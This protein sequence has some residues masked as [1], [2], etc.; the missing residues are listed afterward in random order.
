ME[1]HGFIELYEHIFFPLKNSPIKILEIEI[2]AG[3]SLRVW[4]KYFPE[5]KIYGIDILEKSPFDPE[6]IKTFVAEQ[7][8]RDQLKAFINKYGGDFDI[9]ID[10]GGHPMNQQ[11]ISL[12]FLFKYVKS[13]GYYIIENIHTSFPTYYRDFGVEKGG[14]NS[15]FRLINNFIRKENITS[16]Y[17]T[18]EEEKYLS[19]NV[20]YCNLFFRKN[21][22][23]SIVCV[24]KKKG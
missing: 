18:P 16:K 5:A 12:G 21:K 24:F 15:T 1:A 14:G 13:N 2:G 6:R 22:W 20:E 23:H 19:K 8:N 9:V 11:Q 3:G 7:A 4:R 17:L 10:D